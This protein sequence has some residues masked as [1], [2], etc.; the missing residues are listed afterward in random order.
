MNGAGARKY[1]QGQKKD[2]TNSAKNFRAVRGH[3][4]VKQGFS[5]KSHQKVRTTVFV[6]I[7]VAK[8]LS[9]TFSVPEWSGK[10]S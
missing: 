4:P 10:E 5:G 6:D 3:Y 2:R 1:S 8:V 9:G 7:F